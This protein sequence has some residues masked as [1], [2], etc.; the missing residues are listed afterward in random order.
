M[1]LVKPFAGVCGVGLSALYFW[2]ATEDKSFP[3]KNLLR[4]YTYY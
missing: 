2:I 3:V 1:D 4:N